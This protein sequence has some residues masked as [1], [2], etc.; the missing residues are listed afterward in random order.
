LTKFDFKSFKAI[1]HRYQP[2]DW[3]KFGDNLGEPRIGQ[4]FSI[5]ATIS[6]DVDVDVDVYSAHLEPF[7]GILG[8]LSQ[9]S[10]ILDEI[11]SAASSK[12]VILGGDL[13]TLSHGFARFFSPAPAGDTM[14]FRTFGWSEGEWWHEHILKHWSYPIITPPNTSPTST[15]KI[16]DE[17]YFSSSCSSSMED[18]LFQELG[19]GQLSAAPDDDDRSMEKT[20]SSLLPLPK[21]LSHLNLSN[22]GLIPT[23]PL[24]TPTFRFLHSYIYSAKLD[25]LLLRHF[26]VQE[27][28]LLNND[29]R[30]S[31]HKAIFAKI[32]FQPNRSDWHQHLLTTLGKD[33]KQDYLKVKDDED[34]EDLFIQDDAK[35]MEQIWRE[36]SNQHPIKSY[37]RSILRSR[38]NFTVVLMVSV[39]FFRSFSIFTK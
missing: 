13:N 15:S 27:W 32:A 8:R 14:R 11:R 37:L 20:S 1:D 24:S 4:R 21:C 9:F 2:Y 30:A 34:D 17:A 19:G 10:E 31:D 12:Y 35:R 25:W 38:F 33:K 18:F 5:K 26:K 23:L 6:M 3:N 29:F 36:W 7:T 16:I 22:P 39:F 28:R